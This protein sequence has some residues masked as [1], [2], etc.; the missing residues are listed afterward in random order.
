MDPLSKIRHRKSATRGHMCSKNPALKVLNIFGR[1][2]EKFALMI[3]PHSSLVRKYFSYKFKIRFNFSFNFSSDYL[4]L[5][6]HAKSFSI[7]LDIDLENPY[8]MIILPKSCPLKYPSWFNINLKFLLEVKIYFSILLRT[9]IWTCSITGCTTT[10]WFKL[11][12]SKEKR[13]WEP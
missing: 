6:N 5:Q 3:T 8:F 10:D 2:F 1:R 11:V 9:K 13:L 12:N 7:K 4:L